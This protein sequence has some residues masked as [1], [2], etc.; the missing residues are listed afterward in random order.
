MKQGK[1]EKT[2]LSDKMQDDDFA[3]FGKISN[4]EIKKEKKKPKPTSLSLDETDLMHIDIIY[5]GLYKQDKVRRTT[6]EIMRIALKRMAEELKPSI[7]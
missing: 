5:E 7:S 3:G 2:A 1:L 6:T 4:E